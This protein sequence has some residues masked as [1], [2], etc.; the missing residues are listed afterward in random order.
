[1]TN[2]SITPVSVASERPIDLRDANALKNRLPSAS[3]GLMAR[4]DTYCPKVNDLPARLVAAEHVGSFLVD[5]PRATA[6]Q[7]RAL[8][9]FA[10][11]DRIAAPIQSV[12]V[13]QGP[14]DSADPGRL[15]AFVLSQEVMAEIA[16]ADAPYLPEFLMIPRPD[17]E[18]GPAWSVWR[19]GDRAVVRASDGIGFALRAAMLPSLWARAGH[20]KLYALAGTLGDALPAEDLSAAPPPPDPRDIAFSF[21]RP[22]AAGTEGFAAWRWAAAAAGA[23]LLIHLG[24]TA[25]DTAALK[26]IAQ[27]ERIAAEAAIAGVLPGVPLTGDVGPI[28]ARLTPTP[29]DAGRG[30]FLPLLNEVAGTLAQN[31]AT[32]GF[33]RLSWGRRDNTLVVLMQSPGLEDLQRIEQDLESAGFAVRSGAA[34]AGNGGAEVEMRITGGAGG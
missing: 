15:L 11:E 10:V 21:A 20:P 30:P 29:S 18:G 6:R 25:F 16:S 24:L 5:V 3:S 26:R 22:A 2:Q 19:E 33:R 7:R 9:T 13:V 34:T 32:V 4:A 27:Q 12:Q 14:L 17:P 31:S 8:L 23:A 1:M 28:L